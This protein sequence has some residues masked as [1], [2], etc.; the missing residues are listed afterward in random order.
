MGK[1]REQIER[2][3]Q[4]NAEIKY[5]YKPEITKKFV[6]ENA[7]LKEQNLDLKILNKQLQHTLEEQKAK[8]KDLQKRL[9]KYKNKNKGMDR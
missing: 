4:E 8:N 3:E 1:F 7:E 2:V 6:K 5:L 9:N